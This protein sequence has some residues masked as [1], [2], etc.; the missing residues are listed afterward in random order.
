[1]NEIEKMDS[2]NMILLM[3][4]FHVINY[5][6]PVSEI[7]MFCSQ[8]P[9]RNMFRNSVHNTVIFPERMNGMNKSSIQGLK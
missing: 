2:T 5:V 1:M 4:T 7:C 8:D 6:I 3:R 9:N